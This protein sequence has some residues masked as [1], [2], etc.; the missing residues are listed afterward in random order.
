MSDCSACKRVSTGTTDG[1]RIRAPYLAAALAFLLISLFIGLPARATAGPVAFAPAPT[2]DPPPPPCNDSD[3]DGF[4]HCD[5]VC[6]PQGHACDID[7]GDGRIY[8][9]APCGLC[10]G[11]CPISGFCVP[12]STHLP[13]PDPTNGTVGRDETHS[14]CMNVNSNLIGI[15]SNSSH[16]CLSNLDCGG[17]TR[18]ARR[19]TTPSTGRRR[20]ER[21]SATRR[22]A[23]S[24]PAW[25]TPTTT[26]TAFPTFSTRTARAPSSAT[27][28]TTT[29]TA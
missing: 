15:C 11:N 3:S 5:G 26:A 21:G 14:F 18:A 24:P 29:A 12:G 16:A 8:P 25:T 7:D 4:V 28:R 2:A 13:C 6:D 9:G 22:V 10:N 1:Q 27:A 19:S 23:S 17:G 20:V